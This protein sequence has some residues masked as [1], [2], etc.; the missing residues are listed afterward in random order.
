MM[1][2]YDDDS[3]PDEAEDVL[4]RAWEAYRATNPRPRL[5]ASGVFKYHSYFELRLHRDERVVSWF[6]SLSREL[7]N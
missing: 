6:L 7:V 1:I 4:D 3:S 5:Y 2:D